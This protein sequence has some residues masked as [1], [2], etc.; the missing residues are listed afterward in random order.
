MQEKDRPYLL[1][2]SSHTDGMDRFLDSLKKAGDLE[3]IAV[4]FKP[5]TK[6]LRSLVKID[7]EYPGHFNKWLYVPDGLDPDRY[8]VF[9]DTSDVI[10]QKQLPEFT[11]D[12]YLAPESVDHRNTM[13]KDHIDQFPTLAPLMDKEVLNCGTFAMKAK[14]LYEYRDFIFSFDRKGYGSWP[15]HLEQICFNMFV[16]SRHDLSKVIDRS[17]F[18]PLF[19]NIYHGVKKTDGIWK[20]GKKIISCVHANGSLKDYL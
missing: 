11:H 10:F 2:L 14:H 1:T 20:D 15:H 16:Y 7:L 17:I 5:Y 6:G 13:W 9:S 12:L 8:V 3:H 4:Q 19:A 18:C